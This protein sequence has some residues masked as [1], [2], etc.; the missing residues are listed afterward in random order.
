MDD[1]L[2]MGVVEGTGH[3]PR[4]SQGVINGKLLLARQAIAE[5]FTRH[6]RHDVIEE[7]VGGA[8]VDQPQNVG[9][10]QVG[11]DLDL[12]E[13]TIAA[14]DGAQLGVEDL[15]GDLAAVLEVF[16]EIHRGHTA[17]TQL[18]VEAI[19][20]GESVDEPVRHA[21]AHREAAASRARTSSSQ[22][23]TV[24]SWERVLSPP[25]M[26]IMRKLLSSRLRS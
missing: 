17:L 14:D 22:Y 11:G 4:E 2:A 12:G 9:M 13:E 21:G 18:A 26:P 16:G 8:G 25:G 6:I 23:S 20:V 15:N 10:L 7:A 5:R 19:A 24:M 3:F 1:A